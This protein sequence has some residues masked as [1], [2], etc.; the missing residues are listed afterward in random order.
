M[1]ALLAL[2]SL[3]TPAL[4][5]LPC[6]RLLGGRHAAEPDL[7][8]LRDCAEPL[9]AHSPRCAHVVQPSA[10]I[11]A[12]PENPSYPRGRQ[13][14]LLVARIPAIN[15]QSPRSHVP[16]GRRAGLA[17][18]TSIPGSRPSSSASTAIGTSCW[19]ISAARAAPM[20]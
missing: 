1:A 14:E 17:A 3:M 12:V 10:G 13:I 11:F 16:A 8:L 19:W 15:A 2:N 7:P 4:R 18:G 6:D 9:P 20:H 5:A